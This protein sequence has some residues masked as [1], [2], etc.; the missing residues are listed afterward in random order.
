[1]KRFIT[2]FSVI[3]LAGCASITETKNQSISVNTGEVTGAQ[4]EL[5]NSKG[6]FYVNS[7]PGTVTVRQA[8]DQLVV[9]CKKKGYVP[10]NPE[11]GTIQ[12]KA[13]G[14]AWGNILFGGIIGIAV[15]RS[16]GAGCT[17]PQQSIS[18]PLKKAD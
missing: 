5:R 13:K 3:L 17:Y 2:C 1:M 16:S 11:A 12:D 7:T 10:L 15:D 6:V 9:V 14:M 18:Y 8:C 4:C